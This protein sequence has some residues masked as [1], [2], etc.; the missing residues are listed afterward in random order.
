MSAPEEVM[1]TVVVDVRGR[2]P[3]AG[4]CELER[5][6]GVRGVEDAVGVEVAHVLAHTAISITTVQTHKRDKHHFDS[7]RNRFKS[8]H[9]KIAIECEYCIYII[10][11]HQNSTCTVSY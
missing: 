3:A 8:E 4:G 6:C 5:D 1:R 2:V 7:L 9:L 11:I 10:I